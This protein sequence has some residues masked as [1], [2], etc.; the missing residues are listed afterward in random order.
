MQVYD[1]FGYAIII[2]ELL[3]KDL[4]LPNSTAVFNPYSII[5]NPAI[6]F[7]AI[8]GTGERFY[9]RTIEWENRILV[10]VIKAGEELIAECYQIN[11]SIEVIQNLLRR[12][13]QTK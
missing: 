5:E 4:F 10:K 8:D 9:L 1:P 12:C 13:T 6:V 2:S 11:P 3:N 7:E